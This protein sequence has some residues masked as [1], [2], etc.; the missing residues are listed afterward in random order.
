MKISRH[1][2]VHKHL[3]FFVNNFQ[4]RQPYQVLVDGTFSFA[5]LQNKLNIQDQLPKYFQASVKLL[6]TQCV[7]LETEKL[8]P[9]V[10]GAMLIVKQFAVHK[11][12]HEKEPVTGSKCLRSMIGKNNSHRYIVATQD[13]ELQES[14]RKVPGVPLIYLHQKAPTLEQPSLAS[15]KQ[16]LKYRTTVGMNAQQAETIALLKKQSSLAEES[17]ESMPK[18]KRKKSGPNPLSCKKRKKVVPKQTENTN[19]SGKVRK[20]KKIKVPQHVKEALKGQGAEQ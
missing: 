20:R 11:C 14:V 6:T 13:R 9:K 5:A 7:I 15:Q 17:S 16:A 1:K 8:G 4:F 18:K 12:G 10:F 19:K 3:S 2:K